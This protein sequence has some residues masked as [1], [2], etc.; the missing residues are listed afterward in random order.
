M[1]CPSCSAEV[2]AGYIYCLQCG[3]RI[4]APS[5]TIS[6]PPPTIRLNVPPVDTIPTNR[7]TAGHIQ[8]QAKSSIWL[9]LLYVACG[10]LSIFGGLVLYNMYQGKSSNQETKQYAQESAQNN[11]AG[12]ATKD[13][14]NRASLNDNITSNTAPVA[15]PSIATQNTPTPTS[16]PSLIPKSDL[17]GT[18]TGSF[19]NRDAILYINSQTGDSFSGILKNTKGAIV[20]VSG[21]INRETRQISI[22]ENR[23]VQAATEGPDWILGS[24]SG[25]LSADGRRMRGNG[26][27]RAG[28]VYSFSFT[29]E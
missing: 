14:T 1:I 9:L 26:R 6:E 16:T 20:S 22:Q 28:H 8:T 10:A 25:S 29:K 13:D 2:P 18:W 19:A 12:K 23:V 15:S 21:R 11:N 7:T 3:T 24:N 27:D 17:T 4:S 5:P